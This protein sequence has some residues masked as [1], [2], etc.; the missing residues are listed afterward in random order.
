MLKS[1]LGSASLVL[2]KS[3]KGKEKA[4]GIELDAVKRRSPHTM[5]DVTIY[6]PNPEF[7]P[8]P[9]SDHELSRGGTPMSQKLMRRN[10]RPEPPDEMS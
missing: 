7:K 3:G 6:S 9:S 5:T 1:K 4:G 2:A 8:Q 10:R